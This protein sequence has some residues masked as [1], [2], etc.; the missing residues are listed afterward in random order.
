MLLIV[1][2]QPRYVL[3]LP[4]G[5]EEDEDTQEETDNEIHMKEVYET[6]KRLK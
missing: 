5:H 4:I 3:A 2:Y 1:S 6:V